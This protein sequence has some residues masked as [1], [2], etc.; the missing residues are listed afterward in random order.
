MGIGDGKPGGG[1]GYLQF[2]SVGGA[3]IEGIDGRKA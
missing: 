2:V 1:D 3:M